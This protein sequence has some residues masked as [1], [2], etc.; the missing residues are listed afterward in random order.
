MNNE[1]RILPLRK[2]EVSYIIS[3]DQNDVERTDTFTADF[4]KVEE[5][6]NLFYRTGNVIREYQMAL[7]RI[8]A[9]PV[10][11]TEIPQ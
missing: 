2:Y 5:G 11:V 4:H 3:L 7:V 1:L 9:T 6:R 8:I 10:D